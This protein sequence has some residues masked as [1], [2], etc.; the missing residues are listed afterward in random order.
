MCTCKPRNVGE[1]EKPI[2]VQIM[3]CIA[4]LLHVSLSVFLVHQLCNPTE[5]YV[6]RPVQKH[7]RRVKEYCILLGYT[8]LMTAFKHLHDFGILKQAPFFISLLGLCFS[9]FVPLHPPLP[10]PSPPREFT[11]AVPP[12]LGPTPERAGDL[13]QCGAG[14]GCDGGTAGAVQEGAEWG[15]GCP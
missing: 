6:N 8:I 7:Q 5:A 4:L 3:F 12:R 10:S 2:D 9:Y 1:Q 15:Q 11:C 13:P 14:S